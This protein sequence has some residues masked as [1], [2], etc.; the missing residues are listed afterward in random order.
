MKFGVFGDI[1]KVFVNNSSVMLV[2]LLFEK[3]FSR[4]GLVEMFYEFRENKVK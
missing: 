1:S 2:L 4:D 3:Y